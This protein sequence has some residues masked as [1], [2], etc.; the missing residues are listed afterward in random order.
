MRRH[1]RNTC[2]PGALPARV[3]RRP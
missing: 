3:R 1:A 2:E